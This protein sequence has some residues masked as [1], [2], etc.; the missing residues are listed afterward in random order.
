MSSVRQIQ[1]VPQCV[2]WDILYFTQN[3]AVMIY[4]QQFKVFCQNYDR[5]CTILSEV[6]PNTV[7]SLCS[8]CSRSATRETWIRWA[9]SGRYVSSYVT[10]C[11]ETAGWVFIFPGLWDG[12]PLNLKFSSWANNLL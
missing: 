6:A 5:D 9:C 10:I 4:W 1:I 2:Y 8:L 11:S 3:S 7:S 12:A